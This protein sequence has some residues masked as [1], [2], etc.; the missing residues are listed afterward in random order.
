V[1]LDQLGLLP[2]QSCQFLLRRLLQLAASVTA[3]PDLTR[4]VPIHLHPGVQ[5][6]LVDTKIPRDLRDGLARLLDDP[7]RSSPELRIKATPRG[8]CHDQTLSG[9]ISTLRG[10]PERVPPL[11]ESFIGKFVQGG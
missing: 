6:V 7:H 11:N 4:R 3:A 8:S 1:L 9:S 2:P 10:S 5:R